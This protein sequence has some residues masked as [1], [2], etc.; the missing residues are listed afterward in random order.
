MEFA[1]AKTILWFMF[2]V[3]SVE[4]V[5]AEEGCYG[6]VFVAT[7]VVLTVLITLLVV[8]AVYFWFRKRQKSEHLILETDPEKGKA[9]YA[10][11]NPGFKDATILAKSQDPTKCDPEKAGKQKWNNWAGIS[12]ITAKP[13]KKKTLDDS[14]LKE[15]EVKVVTLKSHDFAGLGFNICGNMKEGIYIKDILHRGPASES[16]KLSPGDRIKSVTINFDHIVY[17]DALSILSFASP[18]E[19]RLEAK[20]GRILFGSSSKSGNPSHPIYR[21]SSNVHLQE[22]MNMSKTRLS[23]ENLTDPNS[24]NLSKSLSNTTTLERK[25]SKSPRPTH[26]QVNKLQNNIFNPE[27]LKNQLEQKINSAETEMRIKAE[28]MKMEIEVQKTENKHQKFGIKVFPT[29]LQR[30]PKSA[31]TSQN[32]NNTNIEKREVH[33]SIDEVDAKTIYSPS[34]DE[35][36]QEKEQFNRNDTAYGSGLKRDENGIP[37]EIP[38]HMLNAAVAARRNRKSQADMI[39]SEE[40]SKVLKKTKGKA[41]S[42]PTDDKS[43]KSN[44]NFNLTDISS[45]MEVSPQ[46]SLHNVEYNSI[47]AENGASNDNGMKNFEEDSE[48]ETDKHS[49]VNTIEL[50]SCDITIHQGENDEKQSRKT[51]STGDLTRIHK[52]RISS[53]GTLER[54]QSLDITD[55]GIPNLTKNTKGG[56][57]RFDLDSDEDFFGQVMLNKEPRLS[58]IL[59]GLNTFQRNR[60]KKS[61]E[62][63]N[64]E[65]AILRSNREEE[66]I[67]P[68]TVHNHSPAN[69]SFNFAE[70]SAE[71]NAVVNKI[72]EIKKESQEIEYVKMKESNDDLHQNIIQ[73][74]DQEKLNLSEKPKNQLWPTETE[75]SITIQPVNPI[76][77]RQKST[78]VTT[79]K[80]NHTNKTNIQNE[81][82]PKELEEIDQRPVGKNEP[83]ITSSIYKI[84]TYKPKY[85]FGTVSPRNFVSVSTESHSSGTEH[86]KIDIEPTR[87]I[88]RT[89]LA[90]NSNEKPDFPLENSNNTD[91]IIEIVANSI[92]IDDMIMSETP[93]EDISELETIEMK[94]RETSNNNEIT[95]V[96]V[97]SNIES[98]EITPEKTKMDKV[99]LHKRQQ[100]PTKDSEKLLPPEMCETDI[101]KEMF[102]EAGTEVSESLNSEFIASS[103]MRS[104]V[105]SHS[106]FERNSETGELY[107]AMNNTDESKTLTDTA[108]KYTKDTESFI[109][110]EKYSNNQEGTYD[111][112]GD[113]NVSDDIKVSRHS[114]GSLERP[115]SDDAKSIESTKYSS[116][117][118]NVTVNNVHAENGTPSMHSLELSVN[119]SSGEAT[120]SLQSES[121]LYTT[122]LNQSL[123]TERETSKIS[124]NTPDLIK[125]ATI[126][127]AINTLNGDMNQMVSFEESSNVDQKRAIT[128]NSTNHSETVDMGN[129]K[130]SMENLSKHSSL[131][132]ITEIQVTPTNTNPNVSEIEILTSTNK[133]S[134]HSKSLEAE[135]YVKSYEIKDMEPNKETKT[136]FEV[137]DISE[138]S[139]SSFKIDPEKE[140]HKIQEIAQEQLKKL[141]EMRFSTSSYENSIKNVEKRQSQVELLKSNFEKSPPKTPKTDITRSRIPISTTMKTPPTTPEHKESSANAD[142]EKELFEIMSSSVHSTPMVNTTKY[143]KPAVT[144]N[145]TVT[146]IRTNSRI[147]SGLPV[148]GIRPPVPPKRTD[149]DNDSLSSTNSSISSFKQWVFNPVNSVTSIPSPGKQE[150]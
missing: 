64:L 2:L 131:T 92:N 13:E 88:S 87:T 75:T 129:L 5:S 17:E 84:E 114:F 24:S 61:T 115:K 38:S 73:Q 94:N 59:D 39:F 132:Y 25:D 91:S 35:F 27:Q 122:A 37:Q 6:A 89:I 40:D 79:P 18:Y 43:K 126:T 116:S 77:V 82:W 74:N 146:S 29:D 10:F 62:W 147:P 3:V 51:A 112:R 60:L 76:R 44:E 32:D 65:D 125:N 133:A 100:I 15:Q 57:D 36:L 28:P 145:V 16:G 106:E 119:G 19:I 113:T 72:N 120:N 56:K 90:E 127:E 47:Q 52:T 41:P 107:T 26:N 85:E 138:R 33:T 150:K 23:T 45:D 50:N 103:S 141:P 68:D 31:E 11:D 123:K 135:S 149:Q 67:S 93:P 42:P 30:S 21:S 78:D 66:S 139:S 49:S 80:I 124:I 55:S 105:E 102:A 22:V 144:K 110:N 83:G 134:P 69:S 140:L 137:K 70:Q 142:N 34:T 111:L 12:S 96:N 7:S 99:K 117:V 130:S 108:P 148:S 48:E 8:G 95:T 104:N 109:F 98:I 101:E 97:N 1:M 9:E 14:S 4:I 46:C 81:I 54:A 143:Q 71:F 20:G 118:I 121:E 136:T 63:G 58:L 53:S 86:E 128:I